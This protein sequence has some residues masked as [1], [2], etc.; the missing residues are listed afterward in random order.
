MLGTHN[1]IISSANQYSVIDQIEG[2]NGGRGEN[3]GRVQNDKAEC[4]VLPHNL[5]KG[6]SGESC[7]QCET[8]YSLNFVVYGHSKKDND[9]VFHS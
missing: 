6:I 9:V 3:H 5:R 1:S 4:H 7:H 2:T 8:K